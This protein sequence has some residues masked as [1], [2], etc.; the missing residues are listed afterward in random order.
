M[1]LITCSLEML[2]QRICQSYHAIL[3]HYSVSEDSHSRTAI[4]YNY[5]SHRGSLFCTGIKFDR[6]DLSLFLRFCESNS[7]SVEKSEPL[8]L[9]YITVGSHHHVWWSIRES[10][11]RTVTNSLPKQYFENSDMCPYSKQGLPNVLIFQHISP[12]L[13]K[14]MDLHESS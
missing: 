9:S 8:W 11:M 2:W 7:V 1:F 6:Q 12:Q 3:V 4:A 10:C 14:I 5:G 13:R